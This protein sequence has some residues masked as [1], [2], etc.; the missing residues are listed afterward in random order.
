MSLDER[1][2]AISARLATGAPA[3]L[4]AAPDEEL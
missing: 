4:L 2:E 3:G 1:R